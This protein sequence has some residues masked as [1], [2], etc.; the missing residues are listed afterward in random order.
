[1]TKNLSITGSYDAR[2]NVI[3]YETYKTLID[4]VFE[5]EMRQSI[6]LQ[7]NYRITRDI[8]FGLQAGY[9]FIKSDSRPTRN[10]YGYLTYSQIPGMNISLT[11]SGTYLESDYINGKV[12]GALL[13]RDL[14]NGKFQTSIGYRYVD[15]TFPENL[16]K[17]VQN[18]GEMN[19]YWIFLKNMSFS[20]NY[21][22]TFEKNDLYNRLFL[23]VSKRF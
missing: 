9:R 2:K 18:I 8:V 21:E 13:S 16:Q 19:L 1:M 14:I 4:S 5:N 20:I 3:Y 22:A 17:V 11:L 23:Q 10:I 6:R 12:L 15:Y 7:T